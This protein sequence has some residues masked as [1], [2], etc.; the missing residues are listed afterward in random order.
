MRL[1]LPILVFVGVL[2]ALV[3]SIAHTGQQ[4]LAPCEPHAAPM[5]AG[6]RHYVDAARGR[7]SNPGTSPGRAWRTLARV[8]ASSYRGGDAILL[9]GGQRFRG[10]ICLGAANLRATSPARRLTIGSYGG[11]RATIAAP[12]RTDGIA[13]INVAGVRV[14]GVDMVGRRDPCTEDVNSGYRYGSAGIR[15]EADDINGTLAQG[16]RIDHVD[17]SRFCNGIVVASDDDESR[18]AHVRVSAVRAHDNDDAGVW[19]YDQANTRHSI[20]DVSVTNTRAYRNHAQGGIVLF[21]VDGG[22]VSRSVAFDNAKVAGGVGIW[23]FDATRILFAHN[24]SYRN[25]RRALTA[26]GD[27]FDF[28][29]GVSDSVMEHNYSHD[30]G[31]VG[32]LV[33]SCDEGESFYRIHNIVIRSNLSRNDGSSGQSS[34]YVYGGSPMTGVKI[35]FNRVDSAVGSGPLVDVTGCRSCDADLV[36]DAIPGGPYTSVEMRANTFVSW[37][38]KPLLRVHPGRAAQ[39]VFR[40]NRWRAIAAHFGPQ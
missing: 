4:P 21:G 17:V 8:D 13:A 23:A 27:G 18:I 12:R 3:L 35:F 31:G 16:L 38:D 22:T 20:R 36:D 10:T 14:S 9:R 19:A 37:G 24:E 30:N 11:G 32:F 6:S 33:C 26:D 1:A 5:A 34:L 15:M 28:D 40:Q 39:L 7:D 2:V 25:G 29:L